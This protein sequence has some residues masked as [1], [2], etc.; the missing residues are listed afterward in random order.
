MQRFK[1]NPFTGRLDI[2]DEDIG[3]AGD[4]EFIQGDAGGSVPPNAGKVIFL[5]GGIGCNVTGVIGTNTLTI[6][7]TGG[8]LDWDE[9]AGVAQAME[10]H[11]GY[12]PNNAGLT[13]FTLPAAAVFGDVM[14]I[15]GFGA[16]GWT[17]AQ[18]AGQYIQYGNL[19]STVGAGGSVASTNQF[20]TV[21]LR[22]MVANTTWHVEDSVGVLNIT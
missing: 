4:V 19:A 7:A 8:G 17:L 13:T 20:D 14:K 1:L 3:P 15:M 9:V 2:A 18:G 16:G 12:K 6:D 22:C 10:V 11:H 21:T 5:L